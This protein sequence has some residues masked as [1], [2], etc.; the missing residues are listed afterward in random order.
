MNSTYVP[1]DFGYRVHRERRGSASA[2]FP[3]TS[4]VYTV[5]PTLDE[6]DGDYD[7]KTVRD[8]FSVRV[9][10]KFGEPHTVTKA[11]KEWQR[12]LSYCTVELAQG[13]TPNV[14][15]PANTFHEA[16]A[17]PL[18]NGCRKTFPSVRI[19]IPDDVVCDQLGLSPPPPQG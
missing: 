15:Q 18:G 14:T 16:L 11:T 6:G 5:I 13:N 9:P 3:V 7:G 4:F 19:M 12:L 17:T 8:S 2:V 10:L 1:P